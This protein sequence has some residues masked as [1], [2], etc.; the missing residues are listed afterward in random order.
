MLL[1][2]SHLA[3]FDGEKETSNVNASWQRFHLCTKAFM[4][5]IE[6]QDE[7]YI[8]F[9]DNTMIAGLLGPLECGRQHWRTPT[10]NCTLSTVGPV[11]MDS[12]E[13]QKISTHSNTAS[14][15]TL[16]HIL[17]WGN[18]KHSQNATYLIRQCLQFSPCR[19]PVGQTNINCTTKEGQ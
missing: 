19:E 17:K 12:R 10:L 6:L 5:D 4:V 15:G 11:R 3:I 8:L 2:V 14:I 18:C 1:S 7:V 9:L 13:N 16:S